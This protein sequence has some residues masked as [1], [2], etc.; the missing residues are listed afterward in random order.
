MQQTAIKHSERTTSATAVIT[1][2]QLAGQA[3]IVIAA[4]ALVALCA[5]IS[6]PLGFSPVPITLQ[7]FAVV[8]LGLL[9]A[10]RL[11]FAAMSLYL[12]EGAFGLPVFSPHGP[13]GLGQLIGYTGGYLLAAPFAAALAGLIY[14]SG[15]RNFLTALAGAAAGDLVLLSTGSLWMGVLTHASFP[16][17]LR[18]SIAP[19]LVSD[20]AKVIAAAACAQIFA[21]FTK[22]SGES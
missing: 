10:P 17:L 7:P 20:A 13:G 5:H 18:V 15:K 19:F 22:R 2:R 3:G 12:L 14:R 4:T 6:V 16:V 9:L 8:L 1:A 21:S 11:S